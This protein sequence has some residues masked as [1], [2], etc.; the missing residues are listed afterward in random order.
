MCVREKE[1]MEHRTDAPGKGRGFEFCCGHRV[2]CRLTL[3]D[4]ESVGGKEKEGGSLEVNHAGL[5][6][7]PADTAV[8]V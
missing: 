2:L 4:Q 6:G 1:H 8:C 7:R 3:D 5:Q